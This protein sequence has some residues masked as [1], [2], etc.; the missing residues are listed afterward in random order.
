MKKQYLADAKE[1]L[2]L[3]RNEFSYLEWDLKGKLYTPVC[4]WSH[5]VAEKALKALLF[6]YGIGLIKEHKLE[7]Q[8]LAEIIKINQRAES[9]REVCQFLD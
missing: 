1:F 6:Y 8:L 7:T 9:L 3:A 4:F 5:Q 2:K